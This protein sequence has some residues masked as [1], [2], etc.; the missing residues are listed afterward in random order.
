MRNA[1][2]PVLTTSASRRYTSHPHLAGSGF[3]YITALQ[4]KND[5]EAALGLPQTGIDEHFYE[6]GSAESQSQVYGG[7][8]NLTVWIDT[9]R[10]RFTRVSMRETC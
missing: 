8:D 3:D 4:V 6:A 10:R 1:A 2:P 7:M 5:W 9:V